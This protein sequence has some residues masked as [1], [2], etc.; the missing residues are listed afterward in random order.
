MGLE[1]WSVLP[2]KCEGHIDVHIGRARLMDRRIFSS[3]LVALG[4]ATV[5]D[6]AFGEEKPLAG[7]NN[8]VLVHGAYADG[9]CWIDVIRLLQDAG[10][11]A[12]A[13]QNPL[14]SLA[15]DVAA[16]NRIL[17]LQKGPTV[18]VAHSWGGTVIS[19]AG[20]HPQVRSLVYI[21]ARAPDAGED[22]AALAKRFPAPPAS[23]GVVHAGGFAQL[24]EEAFLRD[25]AGDVPAEKARTLYA[26]QGRIGDTLFSGKTKVAAWRRKP[27]WYA[28][29]TE[30]RTIAPELQRFLAK[31]M[32]ATTK[33][34]P[35]S[36]LS[37]V[38]HPWEVANLIL[39][40][41][42]RA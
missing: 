1:K 6:A 40:A 13:V 28:V 2:L 42:G 14:T 19:E 41:A 26:V 18:L 25:F 23:A 27:T 7:A 35:A 17:D 5:T 38:S 29:S 20:M 4:L 10:L 24:N 9:S 33:E 34:I 3:T 12:T 15:D 30:D 39:A 21:A 32:K 36:H 16:T 22:F 31:R 11:Q 8:V 37:P